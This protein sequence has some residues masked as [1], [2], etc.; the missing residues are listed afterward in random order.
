MSL[1]ASPSLAADGRSFTVGIVAARYNS[2][3]V[4]TLLE[5]VAGELERSGVRG[6]RLT[7][8]RVPGSSELPVAAQWAARRRGIDVVIALGVL[9]RGDTI[10]Y[11]LIADAV[12]H[13]LQQVALAAGVPVINGVIVAENAAQAKARCGGRID[14]GAEFARAALAMAALKK[15]ISR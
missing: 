1:A 14:R 3:M 5:R 12:T 7:V 2:L 8:I 15:R 11:E 9:V 10:H 6:K 13:G 4:E